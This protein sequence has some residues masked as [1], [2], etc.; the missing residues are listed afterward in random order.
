LGSL[1]MCTWAEKTE[2][3]VALDYPPS[4]K[5]IDG[6]KKI[7]DYLR[8]KEKNNKFRRLIV[9]RRD[10]NC[11]VGVKGSNGSLLVEEISKI[12]DCYI[13]TEDDNEFSPNFLDYINN[14]LQLYRD[15]PSVISI[16]GYNLPI[17]ANGY[18]KNI[19]SSQNLSAWGFARWVG[20]EHFPTDYS[21]Y[22]KKIL[23]SPRTLLKIWKKDRRMIGS[24][25]DSAKTGC[26]NGDRIWTLK[27]LIEDKYCICP[28]LSLVRNN[29]HDGTGM[30]C[31]K[32]ES[33]YF[34][35]QEISTSDY[36]RLDE[37]ELK[38]NVMYKR[39]SS[40][41]NKGIKSNMILLVNIL[42]YY[43]LNKK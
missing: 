37:I 39:Q 4:E 27:C 35:S 16:C 40:F 25:I 26:K 13:F 22:C 42:K 23:Q 33:N 31:Q 18:N 14:A 2:V 38:E 15:N 5:Y 3:Y 7:D 19:F 28:T 8:E 29:G 34:A 6:W 11:G 24:L 9:F 20:K 10:H 30:H 17:S 1:E 32:I 43:F 21:C 12:Y 41:F 36:F